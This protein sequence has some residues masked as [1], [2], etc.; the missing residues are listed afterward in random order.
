MRIH[1]LYIVI[2]DRDEESVTCAVSDGHTII[3]LKY[4]VCH[5]TILFL[6][7]D[8]L[9]GIILENQHQFSKIIQ[10]AVKGNIATGRTIHAVFIE[11]F[12]FLT[13]GDFAKYIRVDRRNGAL[14]ITINDDPIGDSHKIFAD[15]SYAEQ[16]K[17]SGYAGFI[18]SPEGTQQLFDKT[19]P[20]GSNNLM[21]LMAVTEGLRLLKN[22]AS[23]QI[24][25]DSRY[26]IRGLAQW[27]HFWMH[28]H[29][30]TAF[31][32]DVKFKDCWQEAYHL[33]D[34]KL[35]ELRWIKGHAG[36]AEHNFCHDLAKASAQKQ[37]K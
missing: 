27:T 9:T 29:W 31:G 5:K 33:C 32:S 36:N 12:P 30:Q 34:N 13:D 16:L 10:S 11:G 20:H 2:E 28:N 15:G 1:K 21:E 14:C 19:I 4:E 35:V 6:S 25:T 37:T 18:E 8:P 17:Q 7:S 23:I 22:E 26:V 3:R 24:N